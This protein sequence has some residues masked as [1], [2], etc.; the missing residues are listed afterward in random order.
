MLDGMKKG[1][2]FLLNSIWDEEETK[3]ICQIT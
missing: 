2:T 1:G 3:T